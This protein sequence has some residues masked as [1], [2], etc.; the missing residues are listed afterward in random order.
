MSID[1]REFFQATDPSRT[2]FVNN[3]ADVK[4]YI[5]FSSVRGGDIIGKLKHKITFFQPNQPTCTLFTGHIGCGK[6]TELLRL[7]AELEKDGFGVVYFESS[8]DL[9][10][11]DVDIA[12]VLLAIARRV[13]QTL[14]KITL[15]ETSK[16]NELLQGAWNVLNSEVTGAEFKTGIGDVG[17]TSEK[18]KFS[19]AFGIGKI[20]AKTKSDPTLRAKLNQYIGP[21]KTNLLEAINRELLEPAIAKLKQQGKQGL[22]VIV[23]NLDR[24][25]NRVKA[26]GRPQ[27]EYLFVDQGEILTKLNCHLVYTMPLAL[28]FSNDY[29]ML[30]QR[31]ED[32][33]VL[34]MVPVQWPDGSVHQQGMALMQ[35]MVLARAFPDMQ[36]QERLGNITDIFDCVATLERLCQLSGGHVRDLLRLLNSWIMEEMQLPLT[37]ATLEQVIRARRNEMTMPISDEEWQLLRHVKQ[38]KKVSDD[39]GYQKLIRSR[40]VFEYRDDGESWFDVNPILAEAREL[41]GL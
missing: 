28:K 6:S 31:F 15:G 18:D 5:D 36:P 3:A 22:V 25:D 32:P 35:Q 16:F 29:G 17:F 33:K 19:L 41:S 38:K 37:R 26:W 8:E 12:D 20:T 23:D 2:L 7:Q 13:S 11:T 27:Q 4:Y 21:Q 30:T 14:D 1:L 34:P 9:E 40:F 24:I 10:M 39:H